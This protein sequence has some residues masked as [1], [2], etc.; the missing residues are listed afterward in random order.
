MSPDV[1]AMLPRAVGLSVA[2]HSPNRAVKT[3]ALVGDLIAD[4]DERGLR[5]LAICLASYVQVATIVAEVM[6]TPTSPIE[7]AVKSAARR[8]GVT[9]AAIRNADRTQEVVDARHVAG[10]AARLYGM[11]LVAI[12]Q[13]LNKDHTTVMN[14]C[15]RVGADRRLR[16]IATDIALAMGWDRDQGEVA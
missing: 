13:A 11:K 16:R 4:L 14:G 1:K 9:V 15:A 10:Y 8:F 5:N 2:V 3:G 12:G 6:D 7:I